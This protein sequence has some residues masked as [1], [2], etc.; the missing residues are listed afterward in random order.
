M[1]WNYCRG[2][3]TQ[4]VERVQERAL[5]AIY[6]D[7][8]TS[9]KQLLEWA[10]L[11]TSLNRRLQDIATIMYS[12]VTEP[13]EFLRH[14]KCKKVTNIFPYPCQQ[15]KG[16]QISQFHQFLLLGAT[17]CKFADVLANFMVIFA[18]V[19]PGVGSPASGHPNT[20]Q[21]RHCAD[22]TS[23]DEVRV[24]HTTQNSHWSKSMRLSIKSD[25]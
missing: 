8:N 19:G 2:S 4:K 5:Q 12:G 9:F 17:R 3:D 13:L 1:I 23:R 7:W 22:N 18:G 11:P 24:A 6:C 10:K 21:L 16:V 14:I 20:L 15:I 25:M